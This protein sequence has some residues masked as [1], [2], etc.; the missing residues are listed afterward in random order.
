MDELKSNFF[1]FNSSPIALKSNCT[2][3]AVYTDYNMGIFGGN[4]YTFINEYA[5]NAISLMQNNMDFKPTESVSISFINCLM[6][7]YCFYQ[8]CKAH[9][10]EAELC[11]KEPI[12]SNEDYQKEALNNRNM[13]FDFVHLHNHYKLNYYKKPEA[14]LQRFYPSEY[15]RINEIIF[16]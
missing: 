15:K 13:K 9:N 7:Q 11:I 3:S 2:N 16:N 6:E 4:N 10:M 5:Q 8:T 12:E 1:N 14:W